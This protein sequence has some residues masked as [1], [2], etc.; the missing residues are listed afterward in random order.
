MSADPGRFSPPRIRHVINVVG[1]NASQ[2]LQRA[3]KVTLET[4][5]RAR[6]YSAG[7]AVVEVVGVGEPVDPAPDP[8]IR[9]APY[10]TRTLKDFP[11]AGTDRPLPLLRDLL[12]AFWLD[13][14]RDSG[15]DPGWD[16]GI[17]T[18][19]DVAVLPHFYE[20]VVDLYREGF[21][22]FTINKRIVDESQLHWSTARLASEVGE[23]HPGHDCFV[24]DPN[25]LRKTDVDLVAVGIPRVGRALLTN[26]QR[27]ANQFATFKE[28]H[29]TFHL[30]L[31]RRWASDADSQAR[32][33]NR[34]ACE[35]VE[36]A[37]ASAV[38]LSNGGRSSP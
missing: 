14:P 7:R 4:L 30:G 37:C 3:Q 38:D 36:R 20:L 31:E 28:L 35:R 12:D 22:A 27:W 25:I 1:P 18:N 29:A 33:F 34:R 16:I 5:S 13:A 32:D 15:R 9:W 17:F 19:I 11:D 10:L 24:F 26:L 8:R 2:S 6:T 21:D 23:S